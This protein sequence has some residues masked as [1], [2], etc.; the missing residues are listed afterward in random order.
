MAL[1]WGEGHGSAIHDHSNADCFVKV[2]DGQLQETL[3]DWPKDGAYESQPLSEKHRMIVKKNEVA[4][5]CGT[6]HQHVNP[7]A[8]ET[9]HSV[10]SI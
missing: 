6:Y 8:K 3:Y 1:C 10:R 4:Y 5:M 7:N 2:L 9:T